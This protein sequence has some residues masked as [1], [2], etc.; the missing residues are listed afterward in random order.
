M[1]P[2]SKYH[3]YTGL[4]VTYFVS[5]FRKF[6]GPGQFFPYVLYFTGKGFTKYLN[7]KEDIQL[8]IIYNFGFCRRKMLPTLIRM[9]L[10]A[11]YGAL[12]M[13]LFAED[14]K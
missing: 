9:H 1:F 6:A 10:I 12:P 14:A 8:S 11:F 5:S 13:C 2:V 3:Q 7:A 4:S